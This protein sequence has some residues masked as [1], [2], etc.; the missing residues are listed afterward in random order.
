MI[1]FLYSI[2]FFFICMGLIGY[3]KLTKGI[4]Y[5]YFF[6]IVLF[7]GLSLQYAVDTEQ[8]MYYYDYAVRPIT[9]GLDA[10]LQHFEIGFNIIA[11][12]CKTVTS[13]FVLFQMLLLS[14]EIFLIFKGLKKLF[15]EEMLPY[16]I[17]LLF[18]VYPSLLSAMRQ[19]IAIAIF[20]YA[21]PL[22][23]EEKRPW[24]YFIWIAVATLFHQSSIMLV[25]VYLARFSNKLVSKDW[26]MYAILIVCDIIWAAGISISNDVGII[27]SILSNESFQMGSKYSEYLYDEE[28]L[29]NY[30]I[31]KVLEV[32]VTVILYTIFCKKDKYYDFFRLILLIFVIVSFVFGGLFAHR[33]LYYLNI[34]YYCCFIRS[35]IAVLSS[36][37]S[38]RL[39]GYSLISMYMIW[40]YVFKKLYIEYDYVLLLFNNNYQLNN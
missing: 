14:F 2:I 18:F 34:L 37:Q 21:L 35:V 23:F 24:R 40:I 28:V 30:G 15:D 32:N 8:Y 12:L 19:G 9:Q 16:I 5:W 13:N 1:Y 36:S 4:Y 22:I 20:I 25:V 26:L 29:S 7:W 38:S 17:P 3:K 31:A 33:I 6:G 10:N 11:A 27:S 39:V